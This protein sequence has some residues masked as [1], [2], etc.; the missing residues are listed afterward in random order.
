MS[1][2]YCDNLDDVASERYKVKLVA[3]G[4][5]MCPYKFEADRWR[6]DP[7]EWPEVS[8]PDIYNYLVETPG[9]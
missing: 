2:E 8:W 9:T 3:S 4:L 1:Y 7:T 6:N 5:D